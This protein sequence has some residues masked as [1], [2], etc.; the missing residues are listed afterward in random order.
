MHVIAWLNLESSF[1][2]ENPKVSR[3]PICRKIGIIKKYA[4]EFESAVEVQPR[5]RK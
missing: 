4:G 1:R 3:S 5:W 2:L